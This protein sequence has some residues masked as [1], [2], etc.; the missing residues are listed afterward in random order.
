MSLISLN[1]LISL[2]ASYPPQPKFIVKVVWSGCITKETNHGIVHISTAQVGLL[3]GMCR[4]L[5]LITKNYIG[6]CITSSIPCIF[7]MDSIANC[8]SLKL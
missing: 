7:A 4:R 3:F 1:S 6:M 5:Q 8:S 2:Y